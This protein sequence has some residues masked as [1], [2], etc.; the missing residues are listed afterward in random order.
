MKLE[1][2]L[3]LALAVMGTANAIAQEGHL[4]PTFAIEGRSVFI[5]EAPTARAIWFNAVKALP[6]GSLLAA[7]FIDHARPE[8]LAEPKTRGVVAKMRPDGKPD[9]TYGNSGTY[10]GMM[11]FD[12]LSVGSRMQEVTSIAVLAD[13]GVIVGGTLNAWI[14]GGFT[15]RIDPEGHLLDSYG[16]GG[17]SMLPFMVMDLDIDS[18]GRVV[19]A[20]IG[21]AEVPALHGVVARIDGTTGALDPS[22]GDGGI[23]DLLEFAGDGSVANHEGG[24]RAVAITAQ[25]EVVVG[26]YQQAED[27]SMAYSLAK[28]VDG[29]LDPSFAAGGWLKF[30]PEWS[31]ASAENVISDIAITPEGSLTLAGEYKDDQSRTFPMLARFSVNGSPDPGFGESTYPGFRRLDVR[32]GFG[33]QRPTA[34]AVQRDGKIL[35]TATAAAG[36]QPSEFIVGRVDA[37]GRLDASFGVDGVSLIET[38]PPSVFAHAYGVTLQGDLPIVV[39]AN[40]HRADEESPIFI[41]ATVMRLSSDRVFSNGFDASE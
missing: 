24:L 13:G 36:E 19:V 35:F 27:F 17:V 11:I 37:Q 29:E 1:T 7:G 20:G 30:K 16:D 31:T 38:P 15:A 23:S 22:F 25:D 10:P 8:P 34:L 12:D 28:L 3:L 2:R 32:E 39:G 9:I 21:R 18:L 33:D 4:D 41:R 26:G 6:D 40:G 14:F 5:P